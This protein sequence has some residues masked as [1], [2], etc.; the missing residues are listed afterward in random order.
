VLGT[1]F[2]QF[3]E[4]GDG[5]GAMSAVL[6]TTIGM[7]LAAGA[8]AALLPRHARPEDAAT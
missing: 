4:A 7:T 1:V 2:F 6:W 8:L 3:F 5:L